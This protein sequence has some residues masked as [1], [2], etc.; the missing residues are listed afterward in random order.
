MT[1]S[2]PEQL[3][4]AQ[5]R[6]PEDVLD[7][8][9]LHL[10]DALAVGLAASRM[11]PVRGLGALATSQGS[12]RCTILGAT[13]TVPAPI[14]ALVNGGFV[15]SLE[16]DDTH[17]A[18]IMHGGAVMAPAALAVAEEAGSTGRDTLAAFAVGWELLIRIGLA[19]PGRIQAQGFQI[20]SAA[21]AFA[22][23]AVSCL[24]RGDSP[25]VFGHAIGIAGSQAA[26][27]FAFLAGGDTVKA[28]QPAWSAHAGLLAA[29]LARAGVTGPVDV[30]GGTYGFFA[31]YARD[32]DGAANLTRQ[33]ADLGDVWH[34]PDAAFKLQPCCHF[35]HPFVEALEML[36]A[37]AVGPD[38]LVRLH[39]WVPEGA[40]PVIAEPWGQRTQPAKAHDAR[41]SLPYVLAAVLA[42]GDLDVAMF[43]GD[44]DEGVMRISER[45]T[46]E[47]W[48]D[49]G[50]P[51]HFPAKLR[52][53]L[54]DGS[55]LEAAVDDVLGSPT[56]PVTTDDVLAKAISNLVAGGL[57]EREARALAVELLDADD[58]DLGAIGAALRLGHPT[59]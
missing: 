38:N 27:T 37:Q 58:P 9:R 44:C 11:G 53:E 29:E 21:G 3:V 16:Y 46:Y 22:S 1:G 34:L 15:H 39:C 40:V 5:Q 10:L 43:D 41:W 8:A 52:A 36:R 56:R 35:I 55:H 14:A 51:A 23:A 2:L 4:R 19:S 6:V 25:A 50:F 7:A 57:A 32:P 49:S 18:S 30:F 45:I 20:T 31:L 12:G 48:P 26:G 33:L 42:N 47:P 24:L 17:V 59:R 54:S 28:V 13:A